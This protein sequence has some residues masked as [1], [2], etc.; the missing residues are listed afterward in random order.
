MSAVYATDE[1]GRPFIIVREQNNKAR[2]TGLEAQKVRHDYYYIGNGGEEMHKQMD[3]WWSDGYDASC[4][5]N[6]TYPPSMILL[7]TQMESGIIIRP[8]L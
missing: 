4:T 5:P 3:G 8:L 2:L 7:N 6:I 1:Y